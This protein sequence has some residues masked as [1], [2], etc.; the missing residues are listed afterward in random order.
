[1]NAR[2]HAWMKPARIRRTRL[3]AAYAVLPWGYMS[4]RWI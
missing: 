3:S 2:G 1:M 4:M